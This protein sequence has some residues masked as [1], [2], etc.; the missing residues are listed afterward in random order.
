[1]IYVNYMLLVIAIAV[2]MLAV[3]DVA[4]LAELEKY[5]YV[6]HCCKEGNVSCLWNFA[7]S[8][9]SDFDPTY[10][11]PTAKPRDLIP[12]FGYDVAGK[13]AFVLKTGACVDYALALA[14]ALEDLG[15]ET[16]VVS[17][18]GVDHAFPE[19]LAMGKWYVFDVTYTTPDKPVEARLWARHLAETRSPIYNATAR[20][21][22]LRTGRD[23]TEEH[24]FNTTTVVI[25]VVVAT[26]P[27]EAEIPA[28]GAKVEVYVPIRRSFYHSLAYKGVADREGVVKFDVVSGRDYIVVAKLESSGVELSGAEHVHIPLEGKIV[29]MTLRIYLNVDPKPLSQ[30]DLFLNWIIIYTLHNVD[31]VRHLL[32]WT[33]SVIEKLVANPPHRVQW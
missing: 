33:I 18:M 26:T 10:S 17:V 14:K 13:T 16:R 7:K 29:N 19:V 23:L 3:V 28:S 11:I 1:M 2:L 27:R 5:R 15:C 30:G 4:Y 21:V 24:G 32:N 9:W 8:L 6:S 20:L 31:T 25:K 22:E 12:L